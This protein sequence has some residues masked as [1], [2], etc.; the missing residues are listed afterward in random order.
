MVNDKISG[1]FK[2]Y[3]FIEYEK[4]ADMKSAYHD[5]DAKK[6]NG[7]RVLVDVERGRTVE[8][9]RPRRLGGGLGRT[10]VGGPDKNQRYSGRD[11]RGNPANA[12]LPDDHHHY[13]ERLRSPSP[14]ASRRRSRDDRRSYRR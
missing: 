2:G 12:G 9:W 5:A 10:R 1:K 8:S 7:R 14:D 11:P 6:I 4:E 13:K 3:A